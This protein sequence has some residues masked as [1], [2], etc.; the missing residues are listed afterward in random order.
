[1]RASILVLA[2]LLSAPCPGQGSLTWHGD[3][4]AARALAAKERKPLLVLFRC[5]R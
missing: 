3:L 2:A 1:M 5:E 4:D